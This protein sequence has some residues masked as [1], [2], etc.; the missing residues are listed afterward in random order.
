[1][2]LFGFFGCR[3]VKIINDNGLSRLLVIKKEEFQ[4][5]IMYLYNQFMYVYY[6]DPQ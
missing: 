5:L 2:K 3:V 4:I 1:M 6:V